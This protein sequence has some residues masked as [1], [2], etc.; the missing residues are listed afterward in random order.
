MIYYISSD[1]WGRNI[2]LVLIS[3]IANLYSSLQVLVIRRDQNDTID[4]FLSFSSFLFDRFCEFLFVKQGWYWF[5]LNVIE[6]TLFWNDANL[7]K[8]YA[9]F[10][11]KDSTPLKTQLRSIP[12]HSTPRLHSMTPLRK[13]ESLNRHIFCFGLRTLSPC[14]KLESITLHEQWISAPFGKGTTCNK[15]IL[16]NLNDPRSRQCRTKIGVPA[17]HP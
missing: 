14:V 2:F 15:T 11:F 13:L 3:H 1:G 9:L 10:Y 7:I 17:W 8:N 16:D 6:I 12:L 5:R 4:F